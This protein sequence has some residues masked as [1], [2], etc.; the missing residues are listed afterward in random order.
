MN[1]KLTFRQWLKHQRW[2]DDLIG[3]LANDLLDDRC[4]RWLRT[5]EA[6]RGHILYAHHPCPGAVE[7]LNEAIEEYLLEVSNG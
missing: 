5:P 3:D 6:I 4:A 2:R 1:K 7:A